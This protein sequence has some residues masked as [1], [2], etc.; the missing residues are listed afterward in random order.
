MGLFKSYSLSA[1]LTALITGITTAG[2]IAGFAAVTVIDAR[3]F[4][5]DL[6]ADAALSARLAAG[7]CVAPLAFGY[8]EEA[9]QALEKLSIFEDIL[10]VAVYDG[11]GKLFA[12]YLREGAAEPP[13]ALANPALPSAFRGGLF[14]AREPAIFNGRRFGTVVLAAST[15]RLTKKIAG[16]AGLL[17]LLASLT[18][19]AA[20]LVALRAQRVVS[21]PIL[22]LADLARS[23]ARRGD[24]S[25]RTGIRRPD[26]IGVLAAGFDDLLENLEAR[27]RERD[28]AEEALRRAHA[29]MEAK[30]NDRTAELRA[31]NGELEAFTYSASHDLRAPLRRIDGFS[32]LLE[33]DC[34]A[35]LPAEG[36]E[37]LGRIRAGCRQMAQVIDSLLRLSRVMRQELDMRQ[38]DLSALAEEIFAGLR[39]TEPLRKVQFTAAAGLTAVGDRVLLGEVLENLLSNAWKFT[40][41]TAAPVI[42]F[43]AAE[44]AGE[45]IYFVKDN[46]KGF[47]MKYAGKL[48]R[49][50]QR[51]HSPAEFPGTGIGLTTVQRIIERHG[52][53]IWVEGEEDRGAA[54]YFTLHGRENGGSQVHK[55]KG[56]DGKTA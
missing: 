37:H 19:A 22:R 51:L 50:F 6:A 21:E 35:Q 11:E 49:P 55:E 2:V 44:K 43:G 16:R 9:A 36:K 48:F 53:R 46:G 10:S 54:F 56:Y 52:G 24:Y 8:A 1:K 17:A 28:A 42:E 26:E 27:R 39:E 4:R 20:L 7:Y 3:N 23:A 12:R 41:K 13:A 40:G 25:A 18:A 34:A 5:G 15:G 29:E 14:E 33:E 38:L 32:S 30:V 45:K 31:A 47:D